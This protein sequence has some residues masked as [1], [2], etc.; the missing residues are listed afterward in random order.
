M[1]N[2]KS[3]RK[4]GKILVGKV[5]PEWE[6]KHLYISSESKWFC[7]MYSNWKSP[8]LDSKQVGYWHFL[9]ILIIMMEPCFFSRKLSL[10]SER[11]AQSG[12]EEKAVREQSDLRLKLFFCLYIINV[13][14]ITWLCLKDQGPQNDHSLDSMTWCLFKIW[15]RIDV[16]KSSKLVK[17][18]CHYLSP[19]MVESCNTL[20]TKY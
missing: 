17:Q 14:R 16:I 9:E 3:Q 4:M 6:E 18:I 5:K 15:Y 8:Q 10:C 2:E 19:P 11:K 20:W 12:A 1:G 13:F 7:T